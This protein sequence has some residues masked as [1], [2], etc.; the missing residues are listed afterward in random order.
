MYYRRE[1]G[2]IQEK[3]LKEEIEAKKQ[4]S[5]INKNIAKNDNW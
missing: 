1:M 5:E 3:I 4:K 2:K